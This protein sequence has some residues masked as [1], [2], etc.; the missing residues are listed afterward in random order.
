MG[1]QLQESAAL[2]EAKNA[3]ASE[4]QKRRDREEK[5]VLREAS[6]VVRDALAEHQLHDLTKKRLAETLIA[7]APTIEVDDE[8]KLDADKF[9]AHVSEAI[10][11]AKA[12]VAAVTGQ[13]EVTALGES[14]GDGNSPVDGEGTGKVEDAQKALAESF[15]LLGYSEEAAKI[16][17][18]GRAN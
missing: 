18:A 3:T 13:G 6:D 4:K 1:D 9:K 5:L 11:A 7:S 16:A 10:Q 2:T 12:E 14:A 15:Q 8:L 17:A